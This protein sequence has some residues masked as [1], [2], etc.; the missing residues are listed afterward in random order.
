MKTRFVLIAL[1]ALIL[2]LAGCSKD[3]PV[4]PTPPQGTATTVWDNAGSFWQTTVDG[5]SYTAWMGYSFTSKDSISSGVPKPTAIGWDLA[6]RRDN[7]KTNSGISSDNAGDVGGIQLTST[8]FAAVTA[9]DSVGK[10]WKTDAVSYFID[11][12][13]VYDPVHHTLNNNQNVYTMVDAKG[14]NYLK[15]RIDS[16]VGAAM[17]PD[18]GTVYLTYYYNTTADSKDLSGGTTSVV[19]PVG[20]NTVYFDFSAGTVVTPA[21]PKAS[22]DWDLMFSSYNVGQN[23]GPNG[24]AGACAT[25]YVFDYITP[26]SNIDAVTDVYAGQAAAPM[27]GDASSSV[28]YTNSSDNWYNYDGATHQLTSKNYVYL[29]KTG[30]KLYKMQIVSYYANVGGVPKSANYVFKWKEI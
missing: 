9:A 14:H 4:T 29:L 1:A 10:S 8:D 17:P 19:I 3:N 23:S 24:P 2:V 28:F 16:L 18:M 27:F 20:M 21:D 13:Y 26:A 25:F 30:G 5:S 12:W 11:N 7:I 15:F 22:T 6:F